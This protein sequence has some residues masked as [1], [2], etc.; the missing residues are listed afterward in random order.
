[1][2]ILVLNCGSSSVKFQ[3]IDSEKGHFIAKG[4]CE[5]IGSEDGIS[6]YEVP[7]KDKFKEILPLKNHEVAINKIIENLM[8]PER[9]VIKTKNEIHAIGHR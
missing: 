1:M 2:N 5:K 4:L 9:G 7:G 8:H 6:N 3:L